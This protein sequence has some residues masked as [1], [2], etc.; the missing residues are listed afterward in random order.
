MNERALKVLEFNKIIEKL[1]SK[2]SSSLGKEAINDIKVYKDMDTVKRKLAET[3]EVVSIIT[4]FGMIPFGAVHELSQEMKVA[5]VGSYLNIRQILYISDTLR[6]ARKLKSY[7][8][9]FD[10]GNEQF[11]IMTDY[12]QSIYS[13]KYLEDKISKAIVNE[14]EIADHASPELANIRSNIRK[15]N[16]QIRSKL[17]SIISNPKTQKYL[18]DALVT[19]RNDRFVVPVK[20]S[21]KNH[22]KGIV[23]DKSSSGVTLYI[24]PNSVVNLNNKLKSFR[25]DE[26]AEIERILYELTADIAEISDK[27]MSNQVYL[28]KIDAIIAKA[29]LSIEMQG[30]VPRINESRYIRVV[31]GRHPL[32]PKDEVVPLNIWLG[33]EHHSLVI[34]GPN[35]GGKTVTLKTIGLLTLMTM[36]GLHIPADYGTEISI[37]DEV[38]ADIGDEQ[39]IEQ[40]LS[41]FSSHMTNIVS[42]LKNVTENSLVLFDELGAGTDPTEGAALATSIL[43]QLHRKKILTVA[44]THYNELKEYALIEDG[45]ENA[46]V[47]FDI[48]TL[49]PTYKVL[50][51][52]PG[53][54]NAFDI[55]RKLGLSEEVIDEAQMHIKKE[56]VQFEEI[57]SHIE[58]DRKVSEKERNEAVSLRIEIEEMKKK[59]EKEK[60]KF[61]K[62]KKNI[63][64]DAKAEAKSILKAAKRESK[65]IINELRD[66]K[67]KASIDNKRVEELKSKIDSKIKDQNQVLF[68]ESSDHLVPDQ[69]EEGDPVEIVT[70]GQEGTVLEINGDNITVQAGIMKFNV[71]KSNLKRIKHV[72]KDEKPIK[73]PT[74][75]ISKSVKDIKKELDI[76]G[77]NVDE[78]TLIID[79]YLD[80]VYMSSL[81]EVVIIHGKGTGALREG[82]RNYLENHY[83]VKKIRGGEY[84]EGGSGVTVVTLN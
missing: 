18:Q 37:F 46:C 63:V 73:T 32:I 82:V 71:D 5:K 27:I 4:R 3:Q 66:F 33:K 75:R 80:D 74:R 58:K 2:A 19:V 34:T 68:D 83:H 15:T 84:N 59:L 49:S 40:S 57:I 69:L 9:K 76:R 45:I 41:T 10:E 53:K 48:E 42:I 24:E 77:K 22:I 6:T 38:F 70:L 21:Y 67:D 78:A 64:R 36:A 26:E 35:T 44:T 55:S 51:G 17:D 11:P 56:N 47:E 43:K 65:E 52:V 16:D 28:K 1:K 39:S 30:I 61:E 12:A 20:S 8:L 23:H 50:V 7:I 54:S 14:E 79:N 29:N 60:E 81:D 31:N 72:K 25:M 13:F 62:R